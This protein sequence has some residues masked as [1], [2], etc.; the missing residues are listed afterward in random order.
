MPVNMTFDPRTHLG[1]HYFN[2]RGKM[3]NSQEYIEELISEAWASNFVDEYKKEVGICTD[4]INSL[5]KQAARVLIH[6]KMP[7]HDPY[8]YRTPNIR[9]NTI[10]KQ[11]TSLELLRRLLQSKQLIR[12]VFSTSKIT[13]NRRPMS[14]AHLFSVL[15]QNTKIRTRAITRCVGDATLTRW[16]RSFS[17]SFHHAHMETLAQKHTPT[18]LDM[19]D[20]KITEDNIHPLVDT[21]LI[22]QSNVSIDGICTIDDMK[23]INLEDICGNVYV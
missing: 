18:E 11:G 4:T 14:P 15:R 19:F 3:A 9:H 23:D 6:G 16:M 8:K 7:L 21:I 1:T 20:R 2:K 13:A 12:G 10:D 17:L 22:Q 5:A